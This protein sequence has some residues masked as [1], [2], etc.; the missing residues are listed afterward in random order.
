MS[1]FV[2]Y[3]P[4]RLLSAGRS[5]DKRGGSFFL[6]IFCILL[7]GSGCDNSIIYN[8]SE[9]LEN[10]PLIEII[11]DDDEYY[12]LLQNKAT[13]SDVPAKIIYNNEV[14][15]GYLRS[16]GG[17]SRLH[18]RWSYRV[19]LD[20]P[21]EELKWSNFSLSAQSLDPTMMH[22]TIVA[23]L[24][25]LRGIPIFDHQHVFLKINNQDKGLY[26][27]IERIDEHFFEER[28]IPV[29]EI[30]KAG[31]DS[32][33]SFASPLHPRFAYEK[34]V[35][36]DNNYSHLFDFINAIDTCQVSAADLTL[37]EY[38]DID[39]WITYHAVSSLTN[40]GDT[41][42][43]NYYLLRTTA[44]APYRF[45]PWDFDR[46]FNPNNNVGLAG[47]N[48]LFDKLIQNQRIREKYIAEI[49][50][51]LE[52]YFRE[53]ILFPLIDSTAAYIE[54]AYNLDPFLGGGGYNLDFQVSQLKELISYQITFFRENIAD[55][56]QD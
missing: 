30:F 35:P 28:G 20:D 56:K 33:L 27:S 9:T 8:G 46:A 10:M 36:E 39:T 24:Y 44:V 15:M 41:F 22:T 37:A 26:L 51:L 50:L 6:I 23:K 13:K 14:R 21:F 3:P 19:Q 52:N 32:D 12:N 38:L 45:I 54:T 34:N 16:T 29:Y 47:Q 18:P 11:V 25:E 49:Q 55:F 43:N 31:L 42:K 17:G 7:I 48:T 53:D 2:K 4:S 1:V 40:N 5:R